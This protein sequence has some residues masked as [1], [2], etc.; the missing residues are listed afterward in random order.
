MRAGLYSTEL[1]VRWGGFV[2]KRCIVVFIAVLALAFPA[3][4]AGDWRPGKPLPKERLRI[5]VIYVSNP[6]A[7]TSG[8]SF[9]HAQGILEM[10]KN[11]GLA[12]DSVMHR[13]NVDDQDKRDVEDA[14]R[15]LIADG[16]N[17]II[18]TSLGYMDVCEK[19]AQEFS[20]VIF[21]YTS[22]DRH[23]D[24]N[25]T[26]YYGRVYQAR[27]LAGIIAGMKTKSGKIGYVAA[28]GK[29]N[30]DISGGVNA[31]AIGIE[32]AN[33]RARLHVAVTWSW[34]DPMGEANAAR[35]LIAAGCDIIAQ[36]CD[37][38]IPQIEAERAKI[39]GIGY[40]SDMIAEAPN[41]T[42]TSVVW[43]WGAYYTALAESII[44]GSFVPT[45]YF[46]SLKDGVVDIAPL[47]AG[48]AG[49]EAIVRTLRDERQRIVSGEYD[50]FDGIL[51]TNTGE[52]IGSVGGRMADDE[53]KNG[54]HWYYR[55]IV[56]M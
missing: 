34:F 33:P 12:G 37:T 42:L 54:I 22:G 20:E 4:K 53:I 3:C 6:D 27:Y 25:F 26:N 21:T 24:S 55:N 38:P 48:I 39:W 35:R 1:L 13:T 46:G 5:G 14:I 17:V 45:T 28:K 15:S 11:I 47:H 44:S 8:W 51:E 16:A 49:D 23:N 30:S 36:H 43:K 2:M 18:A 10:Q 50:V 40:G 56:E 52:K 9:S 31:F 41:S 29:E 32:R 19:M 7:E